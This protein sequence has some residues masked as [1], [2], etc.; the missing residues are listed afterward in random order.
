M[1]AFPDYGR[2]GLKHKPTSHRHTQ[3]ETLRCYWVIS[4]KL[5]GTCLAAPPVED[6]HGWNCSEQYT[7]A[8]LPPCTKRLRETHLLPH[9]HSC[10]L[11]PEMKT[12][13][14]LGMWHHMTEVSVC[15]DRKSANILNDNYCKGD[16]GHLDEVIG[17]QSFSPLSITLWTSRLT[18]H[19][20]DMAVDWPRCL[21][22][23]CAI[24]P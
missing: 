7:W 22:V 14:L 4:D 9:D 18:Q 19:V 15:E 24:I 12:N 23:G 8:P 10:V 11:P 3:S 6:L 2:Y 13:F 5:V 20:C 21:K 17:S 1:V 16:V